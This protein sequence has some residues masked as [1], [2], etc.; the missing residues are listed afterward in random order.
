MNALKPTILM[1]LISLLLACN[2]AVDSDMPA[3]KNKT[4]AHVDEVQSGDVLA[5]IDG[6]D[7]H[8][9]QLDA[10]LVG[11][12]GQYKASQMDAQS[13][14][15]ALDSMLAGHALSQKAL[16]DLPKEK[17]NAIEEKTRR[18][19]ENLLINAYMQTKMDASTLSSE[20]IK[21]YYNNNIEIFGKQTIKEYQL[22]TTQAELAEE[23]RDKY[24]ATITSQKNNKNIHAIK[25]LLEKQ[26]F[27]VQ[28]H[29]GVLDRN[30]LNQRLYQF[31]DAQTLNKISE[32][33]FIDNK[34]YLVEIT[35]EKTLKAKPLAEVRDT[36][37]KSLILKQLKQ[38]IKEQ[39][40][41][42]LA[43]TN[44]VYRDR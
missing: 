39:S 3:P 29:E 23:S 6:I 2:N 16:H 15:R 35:A 34:P 5:T 42:A 10:V 32:I 25:Q 31:I 30:L 4:S 44:I 1:L 22:L 38:T 7:I 33:T 14:R 12:F 20:K 13:R 27:D 19:R 11:M 17:V 43:N 36:I 24:L 8:E 21:A 26:K 40:A 9:S 37:R 28:L 41:K 18:Y